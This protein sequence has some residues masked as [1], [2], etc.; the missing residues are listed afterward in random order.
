M[1]GAGGKVTANSSTGLPSAEN[2][3]TLA[4]RDI[5]NV[6]A[7]SSTRETISSSDTR[8]SPWTRKVPPPSQMCC[9]GSSWHAGRY[10]PAQAVAKKANVTNAHVLALTDVCML[11]TCRAKGAARTRR[12]APRTGPARPSA[13]EDLR[14]LEQLRV[15]A[16]ELS[17]GGGELDTQDGVA[18]QR[19]HLAELSAS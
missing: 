9:T 3:I 2:Q 13:E 15:H 5:E 1:S 11:A 12:R 17:G 4:S 14:H 6:P 16:L 7:S 8:P 18:L 10:G 19:G